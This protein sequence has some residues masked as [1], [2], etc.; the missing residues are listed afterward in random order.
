MSS[1]PVEQ[2]SPITSTSSALER[3]EHGLDVRAEQHLAAVRQQ[4]DAGLD[5]DLAAGLLEGLARAEDRGLDL[6]DVLR[7][8]DD[9]EVRAALDQA[10]GLLGEDLDE[11]AE[12]ILPSVGSSRAGRC[13][14]GPIEPATKRSS[15]AA[16][17][18]ISAALR[19]DLERVLAEPPLLELQAAGLEGVRLHDLGAGVEHRGVHALDHVRAV[20]DERLVAL[21][22]EAAVVLLGAG[23]TARA[24]RPCR[25]RRRRPGCG[26]RRCSRA[27]PRG[28]LPTLTRCVRVGADGGA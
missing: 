13:P 15:P 14:V 17:R 28:R 3:G 27:W 22:L 23:R 26:R 10:L 7:G 18:A 16:L 1:G 24:S 6:E 19:V 5:R 20:E 8:L 12:R 4:R 21:A 25:R 9:Q 2:F 11:L